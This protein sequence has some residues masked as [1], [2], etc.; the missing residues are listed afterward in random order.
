MDTR[1]DQD[2][3]RAQFLKMLKAVEWYLQL[4]ASSVC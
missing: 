1:G 3:A 4:R 2:S